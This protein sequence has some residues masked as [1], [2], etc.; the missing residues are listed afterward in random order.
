[1]QHRLMPFM[2]YRKVVI[3]RAMP[4]YLSRQL[5]CPERLLPYLQ[6]R[7]QGL[8]H[9]RLPLPDMPPWLHLPIDHQYLPKELHVS[10]PVLQHAHLHLPELLNRLRNLL[11]S[12][13]RSVPNL[14]RPL[15]PQRR[16]VLS[17]M[18]NQLLPRRQQRLQKLRPHQMSN[19][20][21]LVKQLH[22]LPLPQGFSCLQQ[23]ARRKV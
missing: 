18:P 22:R 21:W 11:R 19:L 14:Q 15:V 17:P 5:F 8:R 16:S 2:S 20:L 7:V 13:V 10:Q 6:L 1:M 4:D 3:R 12:Q 23:R 9:Q